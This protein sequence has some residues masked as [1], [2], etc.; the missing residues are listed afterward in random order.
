MRHVLYGSEIV[1]TVQ[2]ALGPAEVRVVADAQHD[3]TKNVLQIFVES[4]LCSPGTEERL[5]D[6][7][8]IQLPHPELIKEPVEFEQALDLAHDIFHRAVKRARQTISTTV[9]T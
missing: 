8:D 5:V 7:P 4:F 3:E 1:D 9:R 6:V 2:T